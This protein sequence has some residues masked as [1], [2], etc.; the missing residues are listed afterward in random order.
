MFENFRK[1]NISFNMLNL[2][3]KHT[4]REIAMCKRVLEGQVVPLN[5]IDNPDRVKEAI[6]QLA[7]IINDNY[8]KYNKK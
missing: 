7:T 5:E 3:T 6:Q 8:K 2:G 4:P 1:S